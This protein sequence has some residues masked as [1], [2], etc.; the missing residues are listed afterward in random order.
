MAHEA[1]VVGMKL[2]LLQAH[3]EAV[4]GLGLG[5]NGQ[6]T[7]EIHREGTIRILCGFAIRSEISGGFPDH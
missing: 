2:K 5:L 7:G 3:H 4:V 1:R 6:V